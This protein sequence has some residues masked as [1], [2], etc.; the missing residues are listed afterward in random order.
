MDI[1]EEFNDM[2]I[3]HIRL[4]E[5]NRCIE[6]DCV[7]L[8]EDIVIH[9]NRADLPKPYEEFVRYMNDYKYINNQFIYAPIKQEPTFEEKII[10]EQ[11]R[12]AKAIE[13]LILLTVGGKVNG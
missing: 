7:Y 13:D 5:E 1:K 6:C 10:K 8:D 12:Q 9:I 4:N 11:E 2:E 3:A